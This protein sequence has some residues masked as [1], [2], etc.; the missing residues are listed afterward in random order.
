MGPLWD[1]LNSFSDSLPCLPLKVT[2]ESREKS[3]LFSSAHVLTRTLT[4]AHPLRMLGQ[5]LCLIH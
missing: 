5:A 4:V 1:S 3:R 2:S